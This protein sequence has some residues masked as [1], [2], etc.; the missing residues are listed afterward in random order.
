[1]YVFLMCK[2]PNA[3]NRCRISAATARVTNAA[4]MGRYTDRLKERK[5]AEKDNTVCSIHTATLQQDSCHLP[6]TYNLF[7]LCKAER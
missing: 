1:M 5:G 6:H 4:K 7:V 3:V 2:I